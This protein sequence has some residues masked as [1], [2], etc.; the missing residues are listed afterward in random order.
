[1]GEYEGEPV[2]VKQVTEL[3]FNWRMEEIPDKDVETSHAF[4]FQ[5]EKAFHVG[6]Q[7][8]SHDKEMTLYFFSTHHQQIGFNIIDIRALTTDKSSTKTHRV[9]HMERFHEG[10]PM[11]IEMYQSK[12]VL[13][14]V[15]CS[16][17]IQVS[18]VSTTSHYSFQPCD[19]NMKSDLWSAFINRQHTDV[20]LVLNQDVVEAHRVVLVSRSPV[21]LAML[22]PEPPARG[23]RRTQIQISDTPLSVLEEFLYF[24]YTGTLKGTPNCHQLL[25]LAEKYQVETLKILCQ[26]GTS[27]RATARD[28]STIIMMTC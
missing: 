25:A 19:K 2:S 1:M 6:I 11:V 17:T 5:N 28:I 7:T 27:K 12:M 13:T 15:P 20:E 8:G 9:I 18:I 10:P 14:Q 21:F 23:A 16:L 3:R 22:G 4:L 26:N 24:L